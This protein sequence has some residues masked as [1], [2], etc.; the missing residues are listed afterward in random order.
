MLRG[1]C[2]VLY[3]VLCFVLRF[4]KRFVLCLFVFSYYVLCPI[5]FFSVLLR[6]AELFMLRF[7]L[8]LALRFGSRF[9]I[10]QL[11]CVSCLPFRILRFV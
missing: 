3:S 2:F 5:V 1:L 9:V 11:C 6:C 7:V 8:R 4:V 10:R